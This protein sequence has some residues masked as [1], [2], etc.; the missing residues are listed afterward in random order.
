MK[1]LS[2]LIF[3]FSLNQL[4]AQV[5]VL[6]NSDK[7]VNG[8]TLFAPAPSDTTYLIDNCGHQ[9]NKWV[10]NY[11]TGH[12]VYLT[13]DGSL[14][15]A[16]KITNSTFPLGGIGGRIEK[17]DWNGNLVWEYNYTD[18]LKSH[19]HDYQILPNGNVL[20]LTI[21]LITQADCISAGRN[22][23]LIP[24]S[25]VLWSE[26]IVEIQPLGT[27]SANIV[28]E[29]R[30]WDHIVQD[31]DASKPNYAPIADHPELI[32]VN[33]SYENPSQSDWLHA[34]AVSYNADL[35]QIIISLKFLSEFWI[36]DHSTTS[37]EAA[38]HSGGSSGKGGDILYR[39][40]NPVIYGAGTSADQQL[41]GQHHVTWIPDGHPGAGNI[42]LYNNGLVGIRAYSSVD[43]LQL[44]VDSLGNYTLQTGSSFAPTSAY[45]SYSAPNFFSNIVSSAQVLQ[46]GNILIC[47]GKKGRFF[48]I[49]SSKNIV[50]EYINPTGANGAIQGQ[51]NPS[52]ALSF[53]AI[54]YTPDYAAFTGKTLTPGNPIENSPW[55]TNCVIYNSYNNIKALE[56][57]FL[58]YPNPSHQNIIIEIE[59][60][61]ELSVFNNLGQLVFTSPINSNSYTLKVA[62]WS[63]GLYWLKVEGYAPKTI[64][65]QH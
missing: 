59:D 10:S 3:L 7:A 9:I 17:Y 56:K 1:L 39:W 26:K 45:W 14:W 25:G 6:T 32:N 60:E 42:S 64:L 41:F 18:S 50:W 36:I 44:P 37:A 65:V 2:L 40:G 57:E 28:W 24:A 34:N 38:S 22:P 4:S 52:P 5:G 16:C 19:H 46:N 58:A 13:P 62:E 54:R 51:T 27:N 20:L 21:E 35:D 31:F 49:D 61:V 23:A 63:N 33:F 48:E 30:A 15:R 8:Y 47:E 29:W 43:L 12:S 55:L 53:R 11:T